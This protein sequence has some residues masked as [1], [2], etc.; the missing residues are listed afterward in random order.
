MAADV[1]LAQKLG[2]ELQYEKESASEAEP[3][4]VSAFK[5]QGVWEVSVALLHCRAELS[6]LTTSV[7]I[8]DTVG[9]DEIA[10]KRKFGNE[11]YAGVPISCGS[12]H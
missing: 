11:K 4:F 12:Q 8:E 6:Y 3:E 1:S 10:L 5:A 9:N 7:K 2:E